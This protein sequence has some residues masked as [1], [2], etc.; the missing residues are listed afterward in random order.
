MIRMISALSKLHVP[1]PRLGSFSSAPDS[2]LA[3]YG[4]ARSEHEG[5][6]DIHNRHQHVRTLRHSGGLQQTLPAR[7]WT[8]LDTLAELCKQGVTALPVFDLR[9]SDEA[10]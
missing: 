1:H 8:V 6:D 5:R 10:D 4:A 3:D 2:G 9:H 7:S